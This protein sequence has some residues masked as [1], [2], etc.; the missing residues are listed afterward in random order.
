MAYRPANH[1]TENG[2]FEKC[3]KDWKI[4]IVFGKNH[5]SFCEFL[6]NSPKISRLV[7][8]VRC[9]VFTNP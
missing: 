7:R 1:R 3:R 4:N 5:N 6:D 8:K 2:I 9:N